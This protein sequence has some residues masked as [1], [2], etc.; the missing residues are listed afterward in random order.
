VAGQLSM[1]AGGEALIFEYHMHLNLKILSLKSIKIPSAFSKSKI[2]LRISLNAGSLSRYSFDL[3]SPIII[4]ECTQTRAI[5]DIE[6]IK[7]AS[8]RIRKKVYI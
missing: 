6:G 7:H 4:L 8:A 2:E 3:F 5:Y 1:G